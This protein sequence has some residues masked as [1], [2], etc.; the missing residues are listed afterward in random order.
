[1]SK[2]PNCGK[3]YKRSSKGNH[4]I[5]YTHRLGYSAPSR[6]GNGPAD[7]RRAEPWITCY[8]SFE[9]LNKEPKF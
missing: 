5:F 6:V 1:M 8:V 9:R 7:E 3:T 2:C 4:G